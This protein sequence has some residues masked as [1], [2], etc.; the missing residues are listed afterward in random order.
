MIV[1][2]Y[3][4]EQI[5]SD[6]SVLPRSTSAFKNKLENMKASQYVQFELPDQFLNY[7]G[8]LNISFKSTMNEQSILNTCNYMTVSSGSEIVTYFVDK[9]EIM[10]FEGIILVDYIYDY[11]VNSRPSFEF[12]YDYI[13]ENN[14]AYAWDARGTV[15]HSDLL[16][17]LDYPR[18]NTIIEEV[19]NYAYAIVLAKGAI[20]RNGGQYPFLGIAALNET[21]ILTND[22]SAQSVIN[23]I[24]SINSTQQGQHTI[25]INQISCIRGE[26]AQKLTEYF[27]LGKVVD[28]ITNLQL[29]DL[30]VL[31]FIEINQSAY[32]YVDID[33]SKT[34][35]EPTRT[36]CKVSTPK[37]SL[38]IINRNQTVTLRLYYSDNN[39]LMRLYSNGNSIDISSDFEVIPD[40]DKE[41][42]T[43]YQTALINNKFNASI[44]NE[45][46]RALLQQTT[47][48]KWGNQA[49]GYALGAVGMLQ[50]PKLGAGIVLNAEFNNKQ[51][52][53]NANIA[54]NERTAIASKN[55]ARA[56][57]MAI[58]R[59][60]TTSS[61][62]ALAGALVYVYEKQALNNL[63]YDSEEAAYYEWYGY[64]GNV[65][66]RSLSRFYSQNIMPSYLQMEDVIIDGKISNS[67]KNILKNALEKGIKFV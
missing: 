50:N 10:L 38:D 41:I 60:P 67:Q 47:L 59:E 54:I 29:P 56:C 42:S 12:G 49:K 64:G 6:Y 30:R 26:I 35:L 16:T 23:T 24:S 15:V 40:V 14:P 46:N 36:L 20:I 9:V 66:M 1:K 31:V 37:Q 63:N 18:N 4:L 22:L 55:D 8:T 3:S 52:E 21:D 43:A 17:E 34:V 44:V 65:Y 57:A 48:N 7:G 51:A 53:I 25:K 19:V 45:Q 27:V 32:P 39:L 13:F 61:M 2:L 33:V 5:Q 11:Y 28:G 62:G 58:M